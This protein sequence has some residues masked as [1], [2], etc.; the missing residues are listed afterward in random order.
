MRC[1]CHESTRCCRKQSWYSSAV[2]SQHGVWKLRTDVLVV[3]WNATAAVG[4]GFIFW[5]AVVSLRSVLAG[6]ALMF[7]E[8]T[9]SCLWV[10]TGLITEGTA[11]LDRE[12]GMVSSTKVCLNGMLAPAAVNSGLY[13]CRFLLAP[14]RSRFRCCLALWILVSVCHTASSIYEDGWPW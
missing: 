11:K 2:R 5:L 1:F 6:S 8:W 3:A 9:S 7:P 4:K 14:R 10:V 12:K 13:D